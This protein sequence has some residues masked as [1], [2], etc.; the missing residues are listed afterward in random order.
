MNGEPGDIHSAALEV[1]EEQHVVGYQPAQR[2]HL[3]GEEVGPCQQLHVSPDEVRPRG[4][5]LA[6]RRRR[7]TVAPQNIANRL[8]GNLVPQISQRSRN[9][10]IAP[11]AGSR[12]PCE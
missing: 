6:L 7:Q 8:I 5:A 10:V 4:C 3:G 11:I 1:D 9:P 12:W 2:Q